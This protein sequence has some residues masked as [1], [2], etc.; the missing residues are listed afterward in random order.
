MGLT[1]NKDAYQAL[2]ED[3]LRW[4]KSTPECLER[5]HIEH[6]LRASV[7]CHYPSEVR[8][9]VRVSSRR[10]PGAEGLLGVSVEVDKVEGEGTHPLEV[11][12]ARRVRRI[13]QKALEDHRKGATLVAQLLEN[14]D[15]G[16]LDDGLRRFVE[17][18]LRKDAGDA[19]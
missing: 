3:D 5:D 8:F 17:S 18:L 2:V 12:A 13:F 10:L 4:L 19:T 11:P 6:M 7:E 9:V 16:N 1:L 14:L 15:N